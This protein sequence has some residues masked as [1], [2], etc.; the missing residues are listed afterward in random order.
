MLAEAGIIATLQT[1][2]NVMMRQ[3]GRR[4]DFEAYFTFWSRRPDPDGN[5]Y[6]FTTCNGAQND[7][8]YCNADVDALLTVAGRGNVRRPPGGVRSPGGH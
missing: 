6:T 3:A 7:S 2:E 4:G 8:H 5:V 1:Q